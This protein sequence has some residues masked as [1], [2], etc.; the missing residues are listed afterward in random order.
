MSSK[1]IKIRTLHDRVLVKRE[2]EEQ[3]TAGG[4]VIPDTAKEKPI[5]GSIVA[6]GTGKVLDNGEIRGLAVKV[7][8]QILFGKSEGT[9][10]V[11]VREVLLMMRAEDSMGIVEG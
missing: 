4:I 1:K 5:R 10:V 7:G 8:D 2:E 3:R 11:I 9:G 6:T